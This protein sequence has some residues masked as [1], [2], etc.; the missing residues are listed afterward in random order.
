ML[1]P[2]AANNK[3]PISCTIVYKKKATFEIGLFS[4]LCHL[5]KVHIFISDLFLNL[6]TIFK[7]K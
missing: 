5:A 4:A 2:S 1:T 3:S 7:F 6:S